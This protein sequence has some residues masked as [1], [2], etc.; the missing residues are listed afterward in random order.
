VSA[1]GSRDARVGLQ[2][3]AI[4][5]AAGLEQVGLELFL[6]ARILVLVEE[7]QREDRLLA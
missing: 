7:V 1:A 6:L 2:L 5:A 4:Q 3:G